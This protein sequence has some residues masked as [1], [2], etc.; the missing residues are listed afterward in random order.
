[1][2]AFEIGYL[3]A[4]T[5]L[6]PLHQK[7]RR[8]LI[9]NALS[10]SKP[11][12]LLDIGGRKS[13]YTIGVPALITIT[14]L[15]KR[16][17][18]QKKLNLGINEEIIEQIKRRR[19]NVHKILF[20]DMTRSSLPDSSFDCVVA[21]EVLEHVEEDEVLVQQV[22]RVLRVGGMFL[23]TT[24]NGDYVINTNPDHKRHYTRSQLED[25]LF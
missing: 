12:D 9:K 22:S 2:T 7:V 15:P 3:L 16:S 18:L 8:Q 13:H 19:S 6:P 25:L 20:D 1:M 10:H 23:T 17:D 24:P 5:F 21:V 14:D 4:E 11:P